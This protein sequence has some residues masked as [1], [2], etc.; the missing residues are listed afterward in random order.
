MDEQEWL[1]CENLDT[2]RHFLNAAGAGDRKFRLFFCACLRRLWH[3]LSDPRSRAAVEAA[4]RFADG[5]A[6][7]EEL[8]KAH[9]RAERAAQPPGNTSAAIAAA[10]V[11]DWVLFLSDITERFEYALHPVVW[12][13]SLEYA[14]HRAL[15]RDIA[16]NP[17]RPLLAPPGLTEEVRSLA[18]A[19][20]QERRLPEGTLDPTRLAV[21]A[22]ALED[23][24]AD[25]ALLAHLRS[26][27]PHIRGCFAVDSLTGRG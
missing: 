17:F 18:E 25:G 2:M 11:A 15:L 8:R 26:G 24:G 12:E 7:A 6:T 10:S 27:G 22:D 14:A 5:L 21:L 23:V 3:L 19:A 13:T 9:R 16:G 20:Y 1:A 4:E